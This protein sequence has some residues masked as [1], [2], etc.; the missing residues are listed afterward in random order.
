MRINKIQ[1]KYPIE[2]STSANA[3]V[4]I[5]RVREMSTKRPNS[6]CQMCFDRVKR[7]VDDYFWKINHFRFLFILFGSFNHIYIFLVKIFS[8]IF[9]CN[10]LKWKENPDRAPWRWIQPWQFN[11][12]HA[13]RF[14]IWSKN[15]NKDKPSRRMTCNFVYFSEFCV[16][17]FQFFPSNF[18]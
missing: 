6:R 14:Q 10:H 2:K 4:W 9:F 11:W 18:R 8:P 7:H 12:T 16:E 15:E 3:I 5:V 13:R 17:L 1:T